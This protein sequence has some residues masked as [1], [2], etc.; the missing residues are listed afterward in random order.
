MYI[1]V[2][3]HVCMVTVWPRLVMTQTGFYFQIIFKSVLKRVLTL[4]TNKLFKSNQIT[5]SFQAFLRPTIKL[6]RIF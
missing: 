2:E 6:C 1:R 5:T 3:N 4:W